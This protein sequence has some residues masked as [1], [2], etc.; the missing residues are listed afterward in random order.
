DV[1]LPRGANPLPPLLPKKHPRH[2]EHRRQ[3]ERQFRARQLSQFEVHHSIEHP[4]HASDR[5]N[6]CR[7]PH[8][9]WTHQ[10]PSRNIYFRHAPVHAR[11]RCHL[12]AAV[13][14][15]HH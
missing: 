7:S 1:E 13:S 15:D 10:P 6:P 2:K 12:P 3:H 8:I 9:H 4:H 11:S 14:P 5:P